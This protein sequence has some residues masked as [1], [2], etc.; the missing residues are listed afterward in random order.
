MN[1]IFS[2][3]FIPTTEQ[4]IEKFSHP[5]CQGQEVEAWIFADKEQRQQLETRLLEVGVKAKIRSAYKPLLH[6]FLEELA[7]DL[8][9][10]TSVEVAYPVHKSASEKRF[11]L[12][13]YPLAA[14]L[15]APVNFS[16]NKDSVDFYKVTLYRLDATPLSY[17][18]FAPNYLHLDV[19]GQ[20]HLSPCGWLKVVNQ[21]GENLENKRLITDYEMLFSSAMKA[22]SEH[23][24]GE[25][26]PYFEELNIQVSLPW[27]EFPLA[28]QH[29]IISLSEALHEDLYFS[30][31]EWFKVKQGYLPTD[32]EGQPGQI[33][34]EITYSANSS[35][36]LSIETRPYQINKTHSLQILEKASAPLSMAQVSAEL[37]LIEGTEFTASTITGQA[38]QARYHYGTDFPVMISGGQHANETTGVVGTLRAAQYLNEQP[39]SHFTISPLENP[40]GY[41]LHQRLINDNPCH[42]HHAARY[43]ALGDDLE[44]RIEAP[45]YEKEIRH[46]ARA[47]SQAKLH[48][49]LHGYPSHEWTRP[50]SGYV[51]HGFTMWTIPKGFFLILRHNSNPEWSAYAEEFIHQV[52][53]EL[54]KLP[55]VLAFNDKQIELY[56]VHAGDSMFR[57][58]NSFP[59]LISHSKEGDIPLQLITEY[60]DETLYGEH[61]I[62]GHNVQTATVLAAYKAHQI[63]SSK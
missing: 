48:I 53:L 13:T 28:Y 14:L 3:N 42:M 16:E 32:R 45:F 2:T 15:E 57:I 58:I 61:F 50:F 31:L 7:L 62:A 30:I 5:E 9:T 6:F 60:P 63:L 55:G 8:S 24:W 34:P 40:D 25:N 39:N 19:I 54:V 1:H 27:K 59:C 23:S 21:Q 41:A 38:I 29:E 35:L 33:V 22:V 49:N 44:Y 17:H 20:Q 37:A 18:V 56:K 36:S 4:L 11:L 26:S 51:P 47:I 12:E 52:T 46:K 10:L 43:T